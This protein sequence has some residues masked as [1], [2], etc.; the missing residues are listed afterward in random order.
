LAVCTP[1][2]C[3]AEGSAGSALLTRFCTRICALSASVPI[4]KVTVSV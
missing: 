1:W 2:V 4:L 3:T